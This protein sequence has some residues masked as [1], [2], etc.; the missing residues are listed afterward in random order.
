MLGVEEGKQGKERK[1]RNFG[2]Q[3]ISTTSNMIGSIGAN[4]TS[5]GKI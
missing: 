1:G 4:R 2:S 5:T 3:E